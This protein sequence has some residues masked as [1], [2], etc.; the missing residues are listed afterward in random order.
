LKIRHGT[1]VDNVITYVC[2]KF[3]TIGSEVK[4]PYGSQQQEQEGEEEEEEEERW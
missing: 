4:E 1:I 3:A 2:A